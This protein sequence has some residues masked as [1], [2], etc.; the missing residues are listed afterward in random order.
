MSFSRGAA[1]K[2]Q[3]C[4]R[5]EGVPFEPINLPFPSGN[6]FFPNP[7]AKKEVPITESF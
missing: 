5:A 4:W 3:L 7:V 1:E 2:A 6:M